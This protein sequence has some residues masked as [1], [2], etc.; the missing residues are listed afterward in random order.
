M[1]QAKTL[2]EASCADDYDPNSMSVEGARALIRRF[3]APLT[4]IEYVVVH[5][6]CHYRYRGHG[7]GFYSLLEAVLPDWR[8]RKRL[9]EAS[10][11]AMHGRA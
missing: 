8:E 7:K 10:I 11:H 2:T 6:L 5:E 1:T 4:A 9:L 3:L